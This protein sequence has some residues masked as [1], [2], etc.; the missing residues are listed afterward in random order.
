MKSAIPTF[1][2]VSFAWQNDVD[3]FKVAPFGRYALNTLIQTVGIVALQL[4]LAA[5]GLRL[6]QGAFLGTGQ[7]VFLRAGRTHD[8][9]ASVFRAGLRHAV[10]DQLA[11][12]VLG[13]HYS[14]RRIRL[15][16]FFAAPES[17]KSINNDVLEAARVDGAGRLRVL[18][19]ILAPMA[20]STFK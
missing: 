11:G 18:Y 14:A 1:W 15:Q 3:V 6:R 17:F 16:H 19:G 12:Y 5:C 8:T 13:A 2:P 7:M 10:E 9:G 20:N 4:N